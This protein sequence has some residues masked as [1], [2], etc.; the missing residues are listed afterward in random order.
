MAMA[1]MEIFLR[2]GLMG[3]ATILL[4]LTLASWYRAREAKLILASAGFGLFMAEGLL[5]V[6]GI[7]YTNIETLNTTMMLVGL[8]FLAMTFLYLSIIKR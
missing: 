6:L 8:N 1:E 4:A 3:M 7:F 2:L 5:L